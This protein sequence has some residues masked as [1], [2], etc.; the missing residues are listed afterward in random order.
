MRHKFDQYFTPD[1]ATK[2]IKNEFVC[3]YP[4]AKIIDPCAGENDILKM[5]PEYETEGF[6]IDVTLCMKHDHTRANILKAPLETYGEYGKCM[7]VTNPPYKYA[8]EVINRCLEITPVVCALLRL[9]FL[10]PAKKRADLV[11]QFRYAYILPERISFLENGKKDFTT[12]AWFVWQ[13]GIP[14]RKIIYP[15]WSV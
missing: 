6:D 5:F 4:T 1:K 14:D 8:T 11:N 2:L 12:H 7:I 10:E 13:Y 9:T 3:D 15:Q